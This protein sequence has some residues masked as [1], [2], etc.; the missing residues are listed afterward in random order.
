MSVLAIDN[1]I[2]RRTPLFEL[3][4]KATGKKRGG[5]GGEGGARGEGVV[6]LGKHL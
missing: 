6:V 3:S 2:L 1:D 5:G 4:P